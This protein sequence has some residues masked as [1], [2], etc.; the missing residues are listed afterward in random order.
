[1]EYFNCGPVE[2]RASGLFHRLDAR[3][4]YRRGAVVEVQWIVWV[5]EEGTFQ[6][7]F[8]VSP[9]W[10]VSQYLNPYCALNTG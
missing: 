7:E 10:F 6:A 5:Y 4:P 2:P 9:L 1:M 3:I 8:A